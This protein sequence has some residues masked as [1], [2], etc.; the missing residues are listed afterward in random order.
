MTIESSPYHNPKTEKILME[1][2][3]V[4]KEIDSKINLRDHME[5][6]YDIV[7]GQIANLR[8][9]YEEL[10][11]EYFDLELGEGTK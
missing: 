1:M 3:D 10:Q 6:E 9:K 8:R 4:K 11:D 2:M 5:S 7:I